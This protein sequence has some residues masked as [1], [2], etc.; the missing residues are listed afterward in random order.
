[1]LEHCGN[2]DPE[3][4]EEY[5]AD[6][7]Y[8][9]LARALTMTPEQVCK[10]V[11][12]AGLR[13]RGGAGFPAGRK[14]DMARVQV[15]DSKYMICNSDEG[16]PGAFMSRSLLEGDPHRVLEGMIIAG[17]AIGPMK[18][19]STCGPNTHWPCS[20]SARP[21]PTQKRRVCWARISW[22]AVSNSMR[23]SKRTQGP[24]SAAKKRP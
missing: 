23:V 3:R 22:A 19:C 11:L 8:Q 2:I 9:A 12:D 20:V 5:I 17:Y 21:S 7:G 4:I 10:E 15:S 6:G 13:G 24:S 14:W 1:M 16:D 18:A